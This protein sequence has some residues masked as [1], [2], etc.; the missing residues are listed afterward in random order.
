MRL[1]TVYPPARLGHPCA[2]VCVLGSELVRA[3]GRMLGPMAAV[4]LVSP[5][6]SGRPLSLAALSLSSGLRLSVRGLAGPSE[7]RPC[8][9]KPRLPLQ[10]PGAAETVQVV[11]EKMPASSPLRRF[12]ACPELARVV[13]SRLRD[14]RATGGYGAVLL[15][16]EPGPGILTRTLLNAGAHVIALES[17]NVFLP[18]LES[19]KQKLDG[20]LE[21]VHCDFFRLDPL[22]VGSMRP[23]I[24][25]SETLFENLD[26][27]A[28]PWTADVPL[29][30]V[31]IV[32]HKRERNLL[33]K[34]IYALYEQNSIYR[35]GRT[36]LNLFV[37]EKEYK[38][39]VAK[40][41]ETRIYQALSVLWQTACDIELLHMEPWSSYSTNSRNGRLSIPKSVLVQNNHLCLVRMTPRKNLFT[42]SLTTINSSIFIV[43]VKQSLAKCRT[44]LIDKLNLWSCGSGKK[45]LRQLEIPENITTGSLY[46][47]QYKCL[48]EAM[49]QSK[50]FDQSW[51]YDDSLEDNRSII[52]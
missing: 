42:E 15:E 6:L 4:A 50:E 35:Y 8:P 25:Y 28:V 36:E 14:G 10:I 48:F 30:V 26:I 7:R 46:P 45:L 12:I 5:G 23:P 29:K 3:S 32:P 51:L 41:E 24:M 52:F 17:N 20:Q 40:P 9:M 38:T 49:V 34:H 22:G 1:R 13:A 19:L 21:V 43:M 37:S 18:G 33:W 47:E 31:G 44:K 2:C 16:C 27:L 11:A 39:L